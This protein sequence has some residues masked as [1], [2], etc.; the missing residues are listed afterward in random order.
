MI[1]SRAI[2]TTSSPFKSRAFSSY[3]SIARPFLSPI[4]SLTRRRTFRFHSSSASIE[5][6]RHH[7]S[8]PGH[9]FHPRRHHVGCLLLCVLWPYARRRIHDQGRSFF[10]PLMA[11]QAWQSVQAMHNHPF[12]ELQPPRTK[13]GVS[14][15]VYLGYS[16]AFDCPFASIAHMLRLNPTRSAE[17]PVFNLASGFLSCATLSSTLSVPLSSVPAAQ[18]GLIDIHFALV[19]RGS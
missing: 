3:A 2:S 16:G 6:S 4:S 8:A 7:S 1:L 5:T 9:L 14:G 11:G 17:D 15:T 12:F 18:R 10:Q 19:A 13:M